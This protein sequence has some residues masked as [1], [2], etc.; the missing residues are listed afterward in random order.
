[1]YC[2]GPRLGSSPNAGWAR[3]SNMGIATSQLSFLRRSGPSSWQVL[4]FLNN[5]LDVFLHRV[6][7]VAE[8]IQIQVDSFVSWSGYTRF[9]NVFGDHIRSARYR[10]TN[11]SERHLSRFP[12]KRM[13]E[14][15]CRHIEAD[16]VRRNVIGLNNIL[17]ILAGGIAPLREFDIHLAVVLSCISLIPRE[18]T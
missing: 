5:N 14:G 13:R 6:L 4:E 10:A 18:Q 8:N 17:R 9:E 2:D 15:S 1:M 16:N 7:F 11:R 12:A 3:H